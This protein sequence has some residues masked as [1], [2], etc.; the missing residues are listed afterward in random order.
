M[1]VLFMGVRY[2]G[3]R[4]KG[5]R[6]KGLGDDSVIPFVITDSNPNTKSWNAFHGRG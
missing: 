5:V 6:Y 2:K 3:V 4:Y 1:G